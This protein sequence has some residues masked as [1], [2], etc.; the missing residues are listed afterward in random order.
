MIKYLKYQEETYE[1]IFMPLP[2]K[3][4]YGHM[5]VGGILLK[6]IE[7]KEV[8]FGLGRAE[9]VFIQEQDDFKGFSNLRPD[10]KLKPSQNEN[11]HKVTPTKPIK[12]NNREEIQAMSKDAEEIL[13]AIRKHAVDNIVH[14]REVTG[15]NQHKL[16]GHLVNLEKAKKIERLKADKKRGAKIKILS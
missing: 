2:G 8:I 1:G 13:S 3:Q 6:D 7:N 12:L 9:E 16:Y 15:V 11:A 5:M 4:N 14:L 10:A